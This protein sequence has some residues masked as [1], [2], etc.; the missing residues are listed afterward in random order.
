MH[1]CLGV[2]EMLNHIFQFVQTESGGN[3]TVLALACTAKC[4]QEAALDTLWQTQASL[5]PLVK[6]F[7]DELLTETRQEDGT[8]KLVSRCLRTINIR[9][10]SKWR[11]RL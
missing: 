10:L 7:P 9:G 6:C 1:R 8:R 4:F 2:P 3:S 5:V 11:S